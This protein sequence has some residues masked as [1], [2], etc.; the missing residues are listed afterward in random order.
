ME[1]C[2]IENPVENESMRP[3]SVSLHGSNH[4]FSGL[5]KVIEEK[6]PIVVENCCTTLSISIYRLSAMVFWLKHF[7]FWDFLALFEYAISVKHIYGIPTVQGIVL[8][9]IK[10]LTFKSFNRNEMVQYGWKWKVIGIV[11]SCLSL[12]NSKV[13][14]LNLAFSLSVVVF[15]DTIK[16]REIACFCIKKHK[17]ETKV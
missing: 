11:R 14:N 8:Q 12:R 6:S 15:R 2:L 10:M 3:R 13:F 5:N 4:V 7:Q 9:N 17:S 1:R 16:T